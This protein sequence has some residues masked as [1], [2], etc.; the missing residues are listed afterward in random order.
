MSPEK[1]TTKQISPLASALRYSEEWNLRTYGLILVSSAA[2]FSRSPGSLEFGS[3]CRKCSA[4]ET[5]SSEESSR[6]IPQSLNLASFSGSYTAS[7]E[8]IAAAAAASD[9]QILRAALTL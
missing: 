7:Q 9:P 4:A 3:R 2:A 5:R 8:P 6:W 1:P